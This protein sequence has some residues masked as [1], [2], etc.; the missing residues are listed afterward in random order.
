[1]VTFDFSEKL[2]VVTGGTKGIGRATAEAFLAAGGRVVVT[3][4]S[5]AAAAETFTAEDSTGRLQTVQCDVSDY[6][7][8]EKFFGDLEDKG[9]TLDIL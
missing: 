2:I 3:Y 4:G 5:D 7:A 6:A 9:E 1:M 8:G